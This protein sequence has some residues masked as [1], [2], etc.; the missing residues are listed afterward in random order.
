MA[1][2]WL[3][4]QDYRR[5]V[6]SIFSRPLFSLPLALPLANFSTISF[7]AS[8]LIASQVVAPFVIVLPAI[9]AVQPPIHQSFHPVFQERPG[10][11]WFFPA[12]WIALFEAPCVAC[13]PFQPRMNYGDGALRGDEILR[14]FAQPIRTQYDPAF[15]PLETAGR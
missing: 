5:F 11:H 8:P 6:L 10:K 15:R 13:L 2:P 4:S 12:W 3:L 7:L 14:S 1:G 9:S